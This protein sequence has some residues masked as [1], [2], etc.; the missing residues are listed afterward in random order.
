MEVEPQ[1]TLENQEWTDT[2]PRP[3]EQVQPVAEWFP[4]EQLQRA[5]PAS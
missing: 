5:A 1:M 4:I 3:D 2:G